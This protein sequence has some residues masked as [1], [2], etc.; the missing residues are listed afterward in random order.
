[1]AGEPTA[2]ARGRRGRGGMGMGSDA[3]AVLLPFSTATTTSPRFCGTAVSHRR[4]GSPPL[5]P[6]RLCF[7]LHCSCHCHTWG[8]PVQEQLATLVLALRSLH[9][10]L[11]RLQFSSHSIDLDA[12]VHLT[13]TRFGRKHPTA[14]VKYGVNCFCSS[15]GPV[16]QRAGTSALDNTIRRHHS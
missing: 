12:A 15:Q 4:S 3:A 9:H 8:N 16:H 6:V 14:T 5:T 13:V 11:R 10:L 1:M 7:P 2:G